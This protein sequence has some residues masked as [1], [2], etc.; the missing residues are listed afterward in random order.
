MVLEKYAKHIFGK[1]VIS[2][3]K[4]AALPCYRPFSA[5]DIPV[6]GSMKS[7][8]GLYIHAGHGTLGWTTSLATAHCLA[9]DVCDKMIGVAERDTFVLPDGTLLDRSLLAPDRFNLF[10][11]IRTGRRPSS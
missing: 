6:V 1:D 7:V 2:T 3:I 8:P 10:S 11:P 4:D 5:D 9:Q